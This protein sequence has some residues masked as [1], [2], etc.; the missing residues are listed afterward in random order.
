M[1]DYNRVKSRRIV[2]WIV[3]NRLG[4]GLDAG[5]V[6]HFLFCVDNWNGNCMFI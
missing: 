1:I 6:V 2:S 3:L 5:G 4:L